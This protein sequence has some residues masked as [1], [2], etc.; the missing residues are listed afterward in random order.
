MYMEIIGFILG[1]LY[2]WLEVRGSI[3]LWIVG[4][5]MPIVYAYVYFDAG[6][7][8]DCGIQIYYVLAA[9]YGW[10]VWK[11]GKGEQQQP[12]PISNT[13]KSVIAPLC[14]VTLLC[15]ALLAWIL[16]HFTDS[17][18][19]YLDAFTTALSITAMWMLS[20]KYIQQWLVWC[21][22]DAIYVGLY[23]YKNLYPTAL[24]Y[25]IYT[26]IAVYGY[27]QWKKELHLNPQ[28]DL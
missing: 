19:P 14:I 6:L 23:I 1:L 17:N 12:L 5:I 8:A 9:I 27:Y 25:A 28:S 26:I 4:A 13:P 16:I 2:L 10:I 3:H 21:C 18:V 7:Y 15:F 24:L 22:V 11:I 20:R